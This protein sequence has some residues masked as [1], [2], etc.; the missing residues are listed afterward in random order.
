MVLPYTTVSGGPSA[1]ERYEAE[2]EYRAVVA[3]ISKQIIERG[4]SLQDLQR[5]IQNAR[6]QMLREGSKYKDLDDAINQNASSEVT[7]QAEITYHVDHALNEKSLGIRLNAV[8]TSTGAVLYPGE[9]FNSPPFPAS[10][11]FASIA[12]K[13]LTTP[14][15]RNGV[16]IDNF[17]NGMQAGFTKMVKEGKPI[18]AI[19]VTDDNS[20]FVLNQ[21]ANE[22]YELIGDKIDEWVSSK[23]VNGVFRVESSSDNRLDMTVNIPMRDANN[24]PY[25][26]KK[27]AKEF[28]IA[29]LKICAKSSTTMGTGDRPDGSS[30]QENIDKGTITLTMPAF[31]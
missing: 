16:Y 11:N 9:L 19:V 2:E 3:G 20:E 23:A 27:F 6:E 14:H 28:R 15:P 24:Q 22:D 31:R 17:M 26:T 12:T 13:I 4:G 21:E 5:T 1:L 8:E 25:S 18:S 30:M 10:T 29:I 7:V